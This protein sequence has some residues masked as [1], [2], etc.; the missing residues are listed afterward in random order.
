MSSRLAALQ[1]EHQ[2]ALSHMDFL[3]R[4]L[5]YQQERAQFQLEAAT[6]SLL[7]ATIRLVVYEELHP[8]E[9]P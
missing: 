4:E 6:E 7:L 8:P 2:R 1:A 9:R 3:K 5:T